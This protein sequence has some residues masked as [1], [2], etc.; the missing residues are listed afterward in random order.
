MM[1]VAAPVTHAPAISWTGAK[2]NE[3][4]YS[5][6]KPMAQPPQRPKAT[7][8]NAFIGEEHVVPTIKPPTHSPQ[9]AAGRKETARK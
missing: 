3:V 8:R 6:M 4:K 1:L 5:V 2:E 9:V 7:Q